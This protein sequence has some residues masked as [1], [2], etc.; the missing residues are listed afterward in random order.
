MFINEI[1]E[2]WTPLM[3]KKCIMIEKDIPN[4]L[5]INIKKIELYSIINNFFLNSADFLKDTKSVEK[6]I[7]IKVKKG[8][9]INDIEIYLEN[10]GP[11]LD[12]K[13]K[14]NP[15]RVFEAGETTKG[16]DGTGLGLWIMKEIVKDNS[17]DI[18]VIDK[19]DGFGIKINIPN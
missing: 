18:S 17:G 14:D 13:Y 19:D 7:S 10:N 6:K 5:Y 16:K 4:D 11:K 1:I 3:K 8:N 2:N 9:K 15:D 12:E